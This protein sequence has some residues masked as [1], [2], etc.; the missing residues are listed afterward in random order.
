MRLNKFYF[1]VIGLFLST[2]LTSCAEVNGALEYV[3]IGTVNETQVQAYVY[4]CPDNYS[5]TVGVKDN[6]ARLY[7]PDRTIKLAHAFSFSGA[8]FSN[9]ET[10]LWINDAQARLEIDSILH[11][12]CIN[13]PDKAIWESAKLNGVDFRALGNQTSWILEIV[14]GSNIIF[15]DYLVQ[16]KQYLFTNPDSNIDVSTGKTIYTASNDEHSIV[17]TIVGTPCQNTISGE[18]FDFSVTV[19]LDNKLFNGCGRSLI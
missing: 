1:P 9:R 7:F 19:K 17:I 10:T 3:H 15:A 14:Q 11:E 6:V 12:G 16:I 8:K 13:N 18:T 5:I 4:E 2:L